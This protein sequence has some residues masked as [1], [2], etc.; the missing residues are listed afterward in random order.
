[1]KSVYV[2]EVLL[3]PKGMPFQVRVYG[4]SPQDATLRVQRMHRQSMVRLL[5][6]DAEVDTMQTH[7]LMDWRYGVDTTVLTGGAN[8]AHR[9]ISLL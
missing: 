3:S 5:N 4:D 2:F 8:A 9:N 6:S 1:M 7:S